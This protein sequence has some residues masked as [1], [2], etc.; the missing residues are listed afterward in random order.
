M[1]PSSS[2][3]S[4]ANFTQFKLERHVERSLQSAWLLSGGHPLDAGDLLKAALLVGRTI[5]SAAFDKLASLVPNP[6]R[7]LASGL[8]VPP[9]LHVGTNDVPPANLAG[10]PLAG[11]LA[12][13][14]SVAEAFLKDQG[15]IWGR[16]YITLS[17]LTKDLAERIGI[18]VSDTATLRGDWYRFVS[19][20]KAHRTPDGWQRWWRAAGVA[21][22][23]ETS[24][25]LRHSYIFAW[26][27]IESP[28]PA[29]NRSIEQVATHGSSVFP[30]SLGNRRDIRRGARIVLMRQGSEP[31]GLLGVGEVCSD[32]QGHSE[33]DGNGTGG[34][35]D[36]ISADV[37]WLALSR[38]PFLDLP[39][40]M[41]ATDS[42][43]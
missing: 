7:E 24:K 21:L 31:R 39:G 6:P 36:E 26:N 33:G 13:S 29:L 40:L 19:S 28:S 8:S 38:E 16:D 10:L 41:Q 25:A 1:A 43:E 18:S 15:T 12:D 22:P 2:A 11:A 3:V 42:E 9:E 4:V 32:V 35:G 17:L 5:R 30:W 23:S 27:P 37:R 34:G 20:S 14:F